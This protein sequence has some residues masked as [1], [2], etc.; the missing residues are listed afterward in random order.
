ML[1]HSFT[2]EVNMKKSNF[3]A[4][5]TDTYVCITP[6]YDLT[7]SI[8]D[9]FRSEVTKWSD[10]TQLNIV[11]DF[12]NVCCLSSRAIT[13]LIGFYRLL[14]GRGK[15]IVLVNV[16]EKLRELLTEINL[17]KIIPV[18]DDIEEFLTR[19]S[20]EEQIARS[21]TPARPQIEIKQGIAIVHMNTEKGAI[22][23]SKTDF[24]RLFSKIDNTKVIVDLKDIASLDEKSISAFVSFAKV[25]KKRRGRLILAEVNETTRELFDLL[26][27]EKH[28]SFKEKVEDAIKIIATG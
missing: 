27:I 12:E 24:E 14:Q 20:D 26:G 25:I 6:L 2:K 10:N 23:S 3:E 17:T 1:A 13:G 22:G 4:E 28:F 21:T 9:E 8:T 15:R 7:D 18:F 5:Q 16:R 19:I 11:L